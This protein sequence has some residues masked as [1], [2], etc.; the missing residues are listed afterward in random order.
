MA[1]VFSSSVFTFPF[2]TVCW[3]SLCDP[4]YQKISYFHANLISYR[5]PL[6]QCN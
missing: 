3:H 4:L 2:S 6:L 1:D 5:H